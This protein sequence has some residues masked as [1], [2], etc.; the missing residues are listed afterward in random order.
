MY[1][2]K[3]P[4]FAQWLF[5][6]LVWRIVNTKKVFLT[7]D[8]GPVP[9]ATPWVLDLLREEDVKAT[10]FCVGENVSRYPDI[11]QR[12]IDEGHS[13]GNHTYNHL[14]AWKT[15]KKTYLSNVNKAKSVIDSRLFRPPYGKLS[16]S[17]SKELEEDYDIIMWD[18]LSGDFDSNI[19]AKKCLDNVKKNVKEGS[20]IVF[21]DSI[22]A[23]DK[24]KYVLPEVIK[25]CKA[26][27]M[28][29]DK[30]KTTSD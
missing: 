18:V 6:K 20:I 11:Y 10:F 16:P 24:L 7:F 25:S 27:G 15:D 28:E 4:L 22:K 26:R 3:T 21:H 5:K 14:N 9:E 17:L 30:I 2:V 29:F 1:L 23:I 8:D 19:S 13:I 12:I